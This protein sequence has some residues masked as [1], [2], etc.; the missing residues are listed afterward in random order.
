MTVDSAGESLLQQSVLTGFVTGDLAWLFELPGGAVSYAVGAEYREERSKDIPPSEDRLGLT[1]GNV[2]EPTLGDFDVREVFAEATVPILADLPLASELTLDAAVRFSDYSTI[3]ETTTWKAGARWAPIP[4][5]TF[6]ATKAEAVR[7]PNVGELF[8]AQSQTFEFID[9]PCDAEAL[10]E[11]TAARIANC[12]TLLTNLG[13][14]D[15][16]A[17]NDLNTAKISGISSG[18]SSL[19]EESAET[20]TVGLVAQPRFLRNFTA[21]L[22][23]YK[24]DI[25]DAI[26]Q[27]S[28]QEIADECVDQPSLANP[29]CPLVEREPGTGRIVGFSVVPVNVAEFT[30]EGYDFSIRYV[31][32]PADFGV[33]QDLGTFGLNLVVNKLE[34]LEFI[35][36][37]GAPAD[38]DL[39]EADVP[40][41]QANFDLTWDRGPWRVNYG[42]NYFDE[43]RRFEVEQIAGEPDIASPDD[44]ELDALFTH[45]ISARFDVNDRFALY[46]GVNNFTDQEP[47]AG[48]S[49]YPVS[50]VGR[51]FF[52]G[53]TTNVPSLGLAR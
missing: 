11:G 9:D 49:T 35:N 10:N 40:E 14:A 24:I 45:D 20:F 37:P 6:R 39:G 22:D 23:Y 30:T 2:I 3:G 17:F 38:D 25:S 50:P 43:T 12:A 34:T 8:G 18:N 48:S 51:F 1:F 53:F 28:S 13:V 42:F 19:Q 4:D 31:L 52:I 7:A 21:A 46:A 32:D 33:Q 41:W 47:D 5:L 36:I 16:A 29:F 27:A 15:P 44:I 26:N